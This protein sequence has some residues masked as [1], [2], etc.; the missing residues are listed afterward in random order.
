M[1]TKQRELISSNGELLKL[2][3]ELGRGGEGSVFSIDG[4]PQKVA[5]IYHKVPEASLQAKLNTMVSEADAALN[6]YVAWPLQVLRERTQGP[7]LG[8][9][10]PKI[11][12]RDAIH[13][14]YSP[15][16]R[17]REK[18]NRKWDFLLLSARNMAA[19][20]EAVHA[21]GHVIGDVNQNGILIGDDG[22][23]ALIDSDS[24]QIRTN[25]NVFRCRVGVP[26]F[27]PPE[28]Q[29][30]TAFASI[31][32]TPNH[33]NFGLAVLVYQLLLG[34]RHPYSGVPLRADVGNDMGAD[35]RAF[36]YAD[37][38]DASKRGLTPPPRSVSASILPAS[39]A[40]MLACAFTEVGVRTARPTAKEWVAELDRLLA[41]VR[42][43]VK[44]PLH[45]F[46]VTT[47]ACPWCA[48][49]QQG[50]SFFAPLALPRGHSGVPS[51]F[52][53]KKLW[54]QLESVPPPKLDAVPTPS[55]SGLSA[56]SRP[57]GVPP[58]AA[59]NVARWVTTSAAAWLS[60]SVSS[61]WPLFVGVGLVVLAIIAGLAKP[62][63]LE[64]AKREEAAERA[65]KAFE[66]LTKHYERA[67]ESFNR[68]KRTLIEMHDEWGR[69]GDKESSELAKLQGSAQSRA[70]RRYLEGCFIDRASIPG[71]GPAKRTALRSF[72]IETAADVDRYAVLQVRG[73]G[74]R[75]TQNMLDWRAQCERRFKFNPSDP[76]LKA[77]EAQVRGKYAAR[78]AEIQR[79]ITNGKQLL[80]TEARRSEQQTRALY[81]GLVQAAEVLAQAQADLGVVS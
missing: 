51:S 7:V 1:A 62:L 73:F 25:G 43:C 41:S 36:R 4:E 58:K 14:V 19:A 57:A 39:V 37:S 21:H 45:V 27:T 40:N 71:V 53:M 3:V 61:L 78:R 64:R 60:V 29:G 5:K 52:D 80:E 2:G 68:R 47:G 33:D 35:I 77:D 56:K 22:R 69:L 20:F 26:E 74:E 55:A 72:G 54:R 16:H 32:R 70:R 50:A 6:R 17:K 28:L 38:Q 44:N 42:T 10:M 65:A 75:L 18:P 49:D 11:A 67:G 23:A 81:P 46:P 34:G 59:I 63:K 79:T 66:D 30:V 31:D 24:F 13:S 48:L 15:A 9:V 8:F 76:A 12:D